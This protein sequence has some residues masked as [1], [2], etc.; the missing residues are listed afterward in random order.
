MKKYFYLMWS[1]CELAFLFLKKCELS[2]VGEG[3]CDQVQ[4]GQGRWALWL[5]DCVLSQR[6]GMFLTVGFEA[7]VR[8]C[9]CVVVGGKDRRGRDKGAT[10]AVWCTFLCHLWI[11]IYCGW[12]WTVPSVCKTVFIND[13]FALKIEIKAMVIYSLFDHH[14]TVNLQFLGRRLEAQI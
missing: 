13:W 8:M 1:I 9:G 5:D 7:M 11:L 12:S 10:A 2:R 14:P 3:S 4:R 6:Y